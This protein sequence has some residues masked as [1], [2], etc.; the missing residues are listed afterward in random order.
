[1]L[2]LVCHSPLPSLLSP[3]TKA[4]HRLPFVVFISFYLNYVYPPL[5][6]FLSL[7]LPAS[8]QRPLS[9][10]SADQIF[11]P[12]MWSKWPAIRCSSLYLKTSA[13][14]LS[15]AADNSC[16]KRNREENSSW[17][18]PDSPKRTF[19]LSFFLA[20]GISICYPHSLLPSSLRLFPS[21]HGI[22]LQGKSVALPRDNNT[23]QDLSQ[24]SWT[25]WD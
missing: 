3:N 9:V 8:L 7:P 17:T 12:H 4:T 11:S 1:M 23:Y 20:T 2:P 15:F 24:S 5:D 16:P 14:I 6:H 25:F 22:C 21:P 18:K 19:S 13:C 10:Q